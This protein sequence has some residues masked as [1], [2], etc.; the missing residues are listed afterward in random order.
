MQVLSNTVGNALTIV[1]EKKA[2]T[3]VDF[4]LRMDKF[5]DCLKIGSYTDGKLTRNPFKQPYRSPNDFRLQ[6]RNFII[7]S[8]DYSYSYSN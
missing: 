8:T 7:V 5:F 3:T 1:V 4:I 2:E 6:V